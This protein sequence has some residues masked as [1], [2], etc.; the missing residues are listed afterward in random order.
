MKE[1]RMAYMNPVMSMLSTEDSQVDT[2]GLLDMISSTQKKLKSSSKSKRSN[3]GLLSRLVDSPTK[4]TEESTE[5]S[6]K[7]DSFVDANKDTK[8]SQEKR[9]QEGYGDCSTFACKLQKSVYGKDVPDTTAGMMKSGAKV[10]NRRP[11]TIGIY[12]TGKGNRHAVTFL[13]NGNVIQLGTSGVKERPANY[14]DSRYP[15]LGNYEF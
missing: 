14:Y 13:P 9:Y 1:L 12:D 11:G 6:S 5:D 10:K 3:E 2:S 4:S 8:Y 7:V 15:L